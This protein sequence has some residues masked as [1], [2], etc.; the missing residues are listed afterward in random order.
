MIAADRQGAI[1]PPA[2]ASEE[3]E[4]TQGS[5]TLPSLEASS[6]IAEAPT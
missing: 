6:L 4:E 2:A 5:A 3:G 1:P